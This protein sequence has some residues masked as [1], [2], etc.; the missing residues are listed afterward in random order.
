MPGFASSDL[1]DSITKDTQNKFLFQN[2]I[3][4]GI[5]S[6]VSDNG[7][8]LAHTAHLSVEHNLNSILSVGIGSSGIGYGEGSATTLFGA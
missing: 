5:T 6:I 2:G 1:K 3:S 7:A 8:G 4:A